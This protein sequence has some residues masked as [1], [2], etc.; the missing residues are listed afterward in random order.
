MMTVCASYWKC[1]ICTFAFRVIVEIL[2]V[3]VYF[4]F[5]FLFLL[6]LEFILFKIDLLMR[7][8]LGMALFIFPFQSIQSQFMEMLKQNRSSFNRN[9]FACILIGCIETREWLTNS[10]YLSG[11]RARVRAFLYIFTRTIELANLI[12][13]MRMR[14]CAFRVRVKLS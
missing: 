7:F 5:F 10:I 13:V 2:F 3:Q 1:I 9:T 11:A 6:F 12:I 4:T 14:C 8:S